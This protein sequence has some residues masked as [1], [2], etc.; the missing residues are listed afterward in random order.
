IRF[1]GYTILEKR[2][3]AKN[4]LVEKTLERNGLQPK[5]VSITDEAID[6]IVRR[7]TREAGVRSLEREIAKAFRKAAKK[8]ASGHNSKIII[9][10]KDI[11]DYL[12]PFRMPETMAEKKDDI[13]MATG[14]AWTQ[15]GGDILFIEVVVMPGKGKLIRTGQLGDV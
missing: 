8:I 12:G 6:L 15:S 11:Q 7:Y 5:Q 9:S 10:P 14:L 1:S 2:F 13:G 4:H 3:I